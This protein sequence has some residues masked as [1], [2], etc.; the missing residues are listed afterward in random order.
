MEVNMSVVT[1]SQTGKDAA[2]TIEEWRTYVR[3]NCAATF[4]SWIDMAV[5]RGKFYD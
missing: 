4:A 3:L 2:T 1:G 5:I